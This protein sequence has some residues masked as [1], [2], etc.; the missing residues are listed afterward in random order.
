MKPLIKLIAGAVLAAGT[1]VPFFAH[2]E[3]LPGDVDR[4]VT[5][6]DLNK[7]G[8]LTRAEIM[9]MAEEM[10]NKMAD[11]NGMIDSK[12]AMRF[13]LELQ[14]SDGGAPVMM[15]KQDVLKKIGAM[16]DKED[17]SKS[18]VLSRAQFER[19]LR[20]LMRSGG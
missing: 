10:I 7:D 11:K 15:S 12:A 8:K 6:Y 1:A 20:E 14:R 19:F 4:Y 16:L 9:K 17:T 13:L 3:L 18:G 5:K 2:A